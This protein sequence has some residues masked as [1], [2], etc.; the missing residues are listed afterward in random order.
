[1]GDF[2]YEKIPQFT[3]ETVK[4]KRPRLMAVVNDN[5]TG[6]EACIEFCPVLCIDHPQPEQY[7]GVVIP[8]VRIRWHECI[9]CQIC[10]RVCEGLAWNAIDMIPI[11]EFERRFGEKVGDAPHPPEKAEEPAEASAPRG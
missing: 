8:P 1:M 11:D 5:C 4:K 2:I 7:T 10:A 9:G 6:C 3:A